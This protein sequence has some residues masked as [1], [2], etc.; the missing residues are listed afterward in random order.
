MEGLRCSGGLGSLIRPSQAVV[1]H[2]LK[3]LERQRTAYQRLAPKPRILLAPPRILAHRL[4]RRGTS[5]ELRRERLV[6]VTTILIPKM[7]HRVT[8]PGPPPLRQLF[9]AP[10][11]HPSQPVSHRNILLRK[12]V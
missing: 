12:R 5:F 10:G 4:L 8:P 2:L 1:C 6:L 11:T 7:Q 3:R 9:R